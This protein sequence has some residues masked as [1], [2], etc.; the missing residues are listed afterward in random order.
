MKNNEKDTKILN[1]INRILKRNGIPSEYVKPDLK[2]ISDRKKIWERSKWRIGVVGITSSGKST[3]INAFCGERI[4][5]EEA[6]PTSG[7]LV[8]CKKGKKRKANIIFENGREKKLSGQDFNKNSI[9]KYADEKNNPNNSYKV[10]EICM[11]FPEFIFDERFEVIDSPGLDAFGLEGHEEITL[12][13]L[14]PSVDM[15]IYLTT[16]KA[17]SDRNN[18]SA[19]NKIADKDKPIVVAQNFIDCIEPEYT[20]G[21]EV[22]KTKEE[23]AETLY[24]RVKNI[25]V[26]SNNKAAN[27]IPLIQIS[28]LWGLKSFLENDKCYLEKS[29]L[30][31]LKEELLNSSERLQD[32]RVEARHNQIKRQLK[33]M[34]KHFEEDYNS[35]RKESIS[36]DILKRLK[37]YKNNYKEYKNKIDQLFEELDAIVKQTKN[38]FERQI[39]RISS[40]TSEN[41]VKEIKNKINNIAFQIQKKTIRK[42][43]SLIERET[44]IFTKFN[45][46]NEDK[47]YGNLNISQ[48]DKLKIEKKKETYQE[49][50][51]RKKKDGFLWLKKVKRAMTGESDYET[52]YVERTKTVLD[53]QTIRQNYKKYSRN[54][55]NQLKKL[56]K[57][58]KKSRKNASKLLNTEIK[59]LENV[60]KSRKNK[61]IHSK[62]IKRLINDIDQ[63]RSEYFDYEIKRNKHNKKTKTKERTNKLNKNTVILNNYKKMI[64]DSDDYGLTE[65][66]L[67]ISSMKKKLYFQGLIDY[68]IQSNFSKDNYPDKLVLVGHDY[69]ILNNFIERF[70]VKINSKS[71]KSV[72]QFKIKDNSYFK[73]F[74]RI[75]QITAVDASDPKL[76]YN[77]LTKSIDTKNSYILIMADIHQYGLTQKHIKGDIY[78]LFINNYKFSFV[79]QSINEYLNQGTLEESFD[80]YKRLVDFTGNNNTGC[81]INNDNPFYSVLFYIADQFSWQAGLG[82]EQK[83]LKKL[84]QDFP[85]LITTK[86][87]KVAGQFF[88]EISQIKKMA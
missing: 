22:R 49:K 68:F 53:I 87:R 45:L 62:V 20:D 84:A 11:E 55:Y 59:R 66:I 44:E 8:S 86:N 77:S 61:P 80:Y 54:F 25:I 32:S 79:I 6:R 14:I 16:T 13:Q 34:K 23:V 5:P 67:K 15:V 46:S 76:S 50:K 43:D 88:K 38:D 57:G 21:A 48:P 26:K 12:R 47:Q 29:G 19:L 52:Y 2:W 7:V 30:P 3:L 83:A 28:A 63:I 18:L 60:K 74:N 85:G 36:E 33:N 75:N 10:D 37:N 65:N 81:I 82:E 64:F 9:A 42:M 71:P 41:T 78:Q 73:I 70:A 31:A 35:Y 40:N 58:W 4:L 51:T 24:M 72:F 56:I 17:N 39:S 69:K 27:N 1:K